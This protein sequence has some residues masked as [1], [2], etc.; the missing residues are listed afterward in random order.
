MTW[1]INVTNM[2]AYV[3]KQFIITRRRH[4]TH[5]IDTRDTR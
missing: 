4:V 5:M 1:R 3:R 2:S